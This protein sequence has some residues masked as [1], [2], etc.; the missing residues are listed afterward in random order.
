MDEDTFLITVTDGAVVSDH[1]TI[2]V[3]EGIDE[4]GATRRFGVD[5]RMAQGLV[6]AIE[7]EGEIMA[8]VEGWQL[9]N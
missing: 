7:D 2:I 5:H 4:E 1:G 9:L 3:F 8:S 6:A